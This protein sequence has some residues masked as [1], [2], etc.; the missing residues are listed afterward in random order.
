MAMHMSTDHKGNQ[1]AKHMAW[2][3][4]QTLSEVPGWMTLFEVSNLPTTGSLTSEN[5][6]I[7]DNEDLDRS[8][9]YGIL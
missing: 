6:V 9:C 8:T 2:T 3:Y 5:H 4:A 1:L 7:T